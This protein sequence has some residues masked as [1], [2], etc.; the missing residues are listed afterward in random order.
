[1]KT[2]IPNKVTPEEVRVLM[3]KH[4]LDQKDLPALI[5]M[6]RQ[7]VNMFMSGDNKSPRSKVPY[8]LY[9]YFNKLEG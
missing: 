5:E 1:M 7:A 4:L 2:E 8:R 9:Q 3:S 6:S